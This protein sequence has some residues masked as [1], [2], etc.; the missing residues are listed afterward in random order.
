MHTIYI[1]VVMAFTLFSAIPMPIPEWNNDN[2]KYMLCALP[3]V[4][5]VIGAVLWGWGWLCALLSLNKLLY[6]AGVTLIPLLI[7]GGIH[8][9]GFCDSVDALSSRAPM[10][11][12]RQILK[13]S[14]AGAFAI[15]FTGVYLVAYLGFASELPLNSGALICAG[16]I[17]VTSR[18]VG[19][20][21]STAFP[22][23]SSEGM[24]A[25]FQDAASKKATAILV[26]IGLLSS[27]ATIFFALA[28]GTA[29]TLVALL[30]LLYIR[31]MSEKQF[32]GMSGDLAGFIITVSSLLMLAA[33]VIAERVFYLCF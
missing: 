32:G 13:D 11:K 29:A 18:V 17:Q 4:G 25:S 15:I 28:G 6:A 7:S 14:H 27:A 31:K 8:M 19:A 1:A 30:C 33:F 10:E 5:V 2:L 22:K 20:I 23:A 3:L 26:V 12:K 16:L 9:D 24:L 21:A